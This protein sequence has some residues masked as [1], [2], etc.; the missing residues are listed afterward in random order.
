[1]VMDFVIAV[2]ANLFVAL[3][4]SFVMRL[5]ARLWN[6]KPCFAG[7]LQPGIHGHAQLCNRRFGCRAESG[8]GLQV[9][10]VGDPDAVFLGPEYD[11]GVTVHGSVFEFQ[12]KLPYY[13]PK[14]AYLI[15][16]CIFPHHERQFGEYHVPVNADVHDI[17][18]IF[19]E[20]SDD[21][22]NP[23]GIKGLGEIGLV[24]VAAAIT[25]AVYHATGK[26]VRD[27]PITLDKL[28]R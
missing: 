4:G 15:R 5:I 23:L 22:I 14:L 1:M 9:R 6:W 19:V 27:L 12:S 7:R 16:L 2:R 20:E 21:I 8:A 13:I 28:R 18:M 26:R 17:K 25:N 24:G 3:F 11:D 10:S